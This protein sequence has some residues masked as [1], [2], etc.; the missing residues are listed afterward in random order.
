MQLDPGGEYTPDVSMCKSGQQSVGFKGATRA[1]RKIGECSAGLENDDV[2]REAICLD[3]YKEACRRIYGGHAEISIYRA[4]VF[5]KPAKQGTNLPWHQD[6]GDWWGLDRDP[7]IF[8]WT[9]IDPAT[10]VIPS[11]THPP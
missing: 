2:F 10:K 1:Y 4:M 7:Q 11:L 9:A 5:N 3:T 8:V 6:G